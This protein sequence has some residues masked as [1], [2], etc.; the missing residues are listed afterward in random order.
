MILSSNN[1]TQNQFIEDE[2]KNVKSPLLSSFNNMFYYEFDKLYQSYGT[3]WYL[4]ADKQLNAKGNPT[5]E[6][7]NNYI[8]YYISATGTFTWY[9]SKYI[10]SV[11]G[12]YGT[13]DQIFTTPKYNYTDEDINKWLDWINKQ[14][15]INN[16]AILTG[17][18]YMAVDE[19]TQRGNVI[20]Y[21]PH[22]KDFMSKYFTTF[23]SKNVLMPFNIENGI[24]DGMFQPVKGVIINNYQNLYSYLSSYQDGSGKNYVSSTNVPLLYQGFDDDD[25]RNETVLNNLDSLDSKPYSCYFW[26]TNAFTKLEVFSITDENLYYKP[27]LGSPIYSLSW[28]KIKTCHSGIV[29]EKRGLVE[30]DSWAVTIVKMEAGFLTK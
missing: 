28:Y 26:D 8:K 4:T 27:L 13:V 15:V 18:S 10:K 6:P 5:K 3:N 14:I 24:I 11:T 17:S 23:P 20:F 19:T 22:D 25:I 30:S 21:V 12:H 29:N 1:F 2:E 7:C 16:G 9:G